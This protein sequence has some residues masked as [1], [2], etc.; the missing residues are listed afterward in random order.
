MADENGNEHNQQVYIYI[1]LY[2]QQRNKLEYTLNYEHTVVE[3]TADMRQNEFKVTQ[4]LFNDKS[5]QI[6]CTGS[7]VPFLEAVND[8]NNGYDDRI[9]V[10]LCSYKCRVSCSIQTVLSTDEIIPARNA[11][12]AHAQYFFWE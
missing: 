7:S 8:T 1:C 4:F 11:I 5:V 12:E 10:A 3:Y 9:F 6:Y 2:E